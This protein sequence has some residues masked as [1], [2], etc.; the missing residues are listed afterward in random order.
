MSKTATSHSYAQLEPGQSV[1]I[2]RQVNE[3]DILMF[4]AVSGDCNP[5][6]L[7]A[8]YAAQT[9]FKER[10][11]HGML[12]GAMI[13]AA[14]ALHLPGP[15]SV[16]LG[17]Q[18]DFLRPVKIGDVLTIE[19]KVLEKLPKNQVRIATNIYNQAGK[20]LVRGEAKVLAPAQ[21]QSVQLPELP[22]FVQQQA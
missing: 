6:H 15:G 10:I 14:I 2:E 9:S 22:E 20:V 21:E 5:V 8:G 4:A 1:T 16:Y 7:D 11:A 3:Q 17:Q 12:S 18:L 19:L 13:S